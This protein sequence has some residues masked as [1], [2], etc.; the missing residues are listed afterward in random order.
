M[1]WYSVPNHSVIVALARYL[2]M[3][4]QTKLE[5]LYIVKENPSVDSWSPVARDINPLLIKTMESKIDAR[6]FVY[7]LPAESSSDKDVRYYKQP[8]GAMLFVRD[9]C[10]KQVA[11][12][13]LIVKQVEQLLK[14]SK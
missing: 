13:A 11:G 10:N 14:D 2:I 1:F 12:W 9:Y 4:T 6:C 8:M 3:S 7:Y 5:T